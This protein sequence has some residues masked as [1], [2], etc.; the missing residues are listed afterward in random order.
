[1]KVIA[2]Y[3]PQFHEV[4]ENSEWWG[5]GFTDWVSAKEARP[6]F[7]G[8]YQPR[9]P[10][11]HYYYDLTDKETLKW[12]ADL[13]RKY[14]VDGLC[15]YHY[16]FKDGRKIL[17]QPVENLL[18]WKDIDMPFCFC[19]ANETWARSWSNIKKKN[20]WTNKN[21][22][23]NCSDENGILLE[24]A[25]GDE[26]AWREHLEYLIPFFKDSRYIKVENKPLLVIYK[27]DDIECINE[28][29]KYWKKE[30]VKYGIDGIYVVGAN[31]NAL[32][33]ESIDAETN[34]EPSSGIQIAKRKQEYDGIA[35]YEYKDIW[36]NILQ[37]GPRAKKTFFGGFVGYD[38]T[39]RHG[40]KGF[41][42][43]GSTPELFGEYLVE[44]MAKNAAYNNDI[45]FLN[46]WNEWG[47]G[48]YLE[49][50]ERYGTKFLEAITYAKSKY[51][52]YIPKYKGKY[53]NKYVTTLRRKGEKFEKYFK[54]MDSWMTLWE[55]N[56]TISDNLI[57][58]DIHSILIY[59][60]G[61]LGRHLLCDLRGTE[62]KVLGIVDKRKNVLSADAAI[63]IPTEELPKC[64]AIVVTASYFM[65][66]IKKQLGNSHRLLSIEDVINY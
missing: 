61:P 49:P 8:H 52:E 15:I 57:K 12:Q 1:M 28:M 38:D 64:D 19:W 9:V 10:L 16:W 29:L 31:C 51:V 2:M 6:L 36:E 39:P 66:E 33:G 48:M 17:E 44:L 37:E 46:A 20:V 40:N 32:A 30:I 35:Y 23:R 60:Y 47:E 59:G 27:S 11:N 25:Y 26:D 13:M 43:K 24:Q 41:L 54:I 14:S 62:I 58:M 53:E 18:Q 34:F 65:R 4:V 3:L 7:E 50:D 56:G 55:K 63:Y 42:V 22:V 21:E 45:V 5:N